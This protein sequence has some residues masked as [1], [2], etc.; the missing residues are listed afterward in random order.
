MRGQHIPEFV[1][2][3]HLI[4]TGRS[5]S[6]WLRLILQRNAGIEL[7]GDKQ[8]ITPFKG[9]GEISPKEFAQFIYGWRRR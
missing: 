1:L 6:G 8:D 2:R 5:Q 9:L 3:V 7:L 4:C